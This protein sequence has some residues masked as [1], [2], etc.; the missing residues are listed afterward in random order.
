MD[1][2]RPRLPVRGGEQFGPDQEIRP[3]EQ[4]RPRPASGQR[5]LIDDPG[6]GPDGFPRR[7]GHVVRPADV[8]DVIPIRAEPLKHGPLV[9]LPAPDQ[10]LEPDIELPRRT[11]LPPRPQQVQLRQPPAGQEVGHIAGRQPHPP[12]NDLHLDP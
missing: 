10:I 7:P 5:P 3:P 2:A 6:P 4:R 1:P 8:D 9:H 12:L 11:Q